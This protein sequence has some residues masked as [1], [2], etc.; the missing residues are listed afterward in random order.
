MPLKKL[1]VADRDYTT[2]EVCRIADVTK[3]DL[4]YWRDNKW[5]PLIGRRGHW[6]YAALMKA[7]LMKRL[8]KAGFKAQAASDIADRLRKQGFTGSVDLG[9]DIVV[10]QE[11]ETDEFNEFLA[12]P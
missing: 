9:Y 12:M 11:L 4:Q 3:A 8:I 6:T 2:A 7:E 10:M 1:A 5:L